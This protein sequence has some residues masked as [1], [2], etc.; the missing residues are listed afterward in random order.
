MFLYIVLYDYIYV[1]NILI[2]F[3]TGYVEGNTLQYVV[4]DLRKI[5]CKYVRTWF[6]VDLASSLSLVPGL[7]HIEDVYLYLIL[8]SIKLLR[9]ST[10]LGYLNNVLIVLRVGVSTYTLFYV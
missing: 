8:I 3:L 5:V 9:I 1:F 4:L 10:L 2:N 6:I 7:F